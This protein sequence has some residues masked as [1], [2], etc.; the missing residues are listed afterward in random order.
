MY[1][2]ID[3]AIVLLTANLFST[4]EDFFILHDPW[5]ITFLTCNALHTYVMITNVKSGTNY[6]QKKKESRIQFKAMVNDR[7]LQLSAILC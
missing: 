6:L 3:R 4:I 2:C 5:H 1:F 7:C